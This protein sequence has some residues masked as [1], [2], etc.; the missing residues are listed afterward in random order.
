[1]VDHGRPI[2]ADRPSDLH[3]QPVSAPAE[4]PPDDTSARCRRRPDDK[5]WCDTADVS[6]QGRRV[7]GGQSG[8]GEEGLRENHRQGLAARGRSRASSRG[9][10]AGKILLGVTISGAANGTVYVVGTPSYDSV[11]KLMTV[12]DLAFD[13]KSQGYLEFSPGGLAPQWPLAG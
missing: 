8:A 13:V 7:R 3:G 2:D 4:R 9:R 12:P 1:M 5:P 6:I 11:T 10:R